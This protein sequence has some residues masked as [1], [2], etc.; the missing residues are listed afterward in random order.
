MSEPVRYVAENAQVE[1][2]RLTFL[3]I[4]DHVR[5]FAEGVSEGEISFADEHILEDFFAYIDA[6][7]QELSRKPEARQ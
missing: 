1:A 5:A 2:L 6:R 4:L 3:G 7:R